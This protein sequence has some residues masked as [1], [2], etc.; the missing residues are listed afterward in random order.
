MSEPVVG[1][2]ERELLD[3]ARDRV[4]AQRRAYYHQLEDIAEL[5]QRG[6]ALATGDRVTDRLVQ[7]LGLYDP[8]EATRLVNE[9]ADLTPRWSLRG[10]LLAPRY[11]HTAQVL[12]AGWVGP[13]HI[14]VIRKAM[15]RLARVETISPE[16]LAGCERILADAA[17]GLPPRTLRK[18]ADRLLAEFD[19][20]GAAPPE[21]AER[22]DECGWC[23]APTGRWRSRV[24]SGIRW[25]PS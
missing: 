13:G 20:D 16:D 1:A 11:P 3:R 18:V 12:A 24:G 4:E 22:W 25:T 23:A 9:A 17:V 21:D 10:E 6:V 15:G 8:A 2:V 14:A 5:E 7:D 19:P